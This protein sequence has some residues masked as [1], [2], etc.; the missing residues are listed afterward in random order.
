MTKIIQ[1]AIL[2]ITLFSANYLVAEKHLISSDQS[3]LAEAIYNEAKSEPLKGQYAVAEVIRNRVK[4]NFAPT[5]CAVVNQ[6]V[7]SHWQF[8]YNVRDK[9]KIPV[10]QRA[11]FNNIADEVLRL[12]EYRVLPDNILYFNNITFSSKEYHLYC[13][14]GKQKFFLREHKKN[15]HKSKVDPLY[16]SHENLLHQNKMAI[17]EG[18]PSIHSDQDLAILVARGELVSIPASS[19]LLIAQQL[20]M[21]RRYCKAWTA[22][23][24]SD[25]SVAYNKQFKKVLIVDSAVRTEIFQKKLERINKNAAAVEGDS[26]S[27]HLKGIAVDINKRNFTDA[28]LDW[29]RSY[30]AEQIFYGRID[31]E[32]EFQQKCFHISVYNPL[33]FGDL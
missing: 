7:G 25:L 3:C 19:T 12:E 5:V 33:I 30:L 31:V 23:F 4:A 8:G 6:H 13:I 32:E 28:E 20:P 14:I 22:S 21:N 15:K 18:L 26:A 27:P 11:Y 29:M 9:K 1:I 17:Q 16:G 24:L 10:T 2:G